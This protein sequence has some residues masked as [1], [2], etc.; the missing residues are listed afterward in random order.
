MRTARLRRVAPRIDATAVVRGFSVP[1]VFGRQA[2]ADPGAILARAVP[3][4][5]VHRMVVA[6]GVAVI[7]VLS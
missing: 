6:A 2:S 1:L 5:A 3:I 4:D 7:A